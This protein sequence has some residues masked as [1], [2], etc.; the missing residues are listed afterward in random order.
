[1]HHVAALRCERARR[2]VSSVLVAL[3]ALAA[4]P[5]W[6]A[7]GEGPALFGIPVD[8][9]LFGVTLICVG[10]FHHHTLAV[11]LTGLA[12]VMAYKI[13]LT[14]FKTGPGLGGLAAHLAHEWVILTN[15]LGLL[16]GFALLARHFE[17]SRVPEA[18]PRVLPDGWKGGLVLLALIFVLSAFLDNI[19]AALIG[20][21]IAGAVY[22]RKVHIGYL[23]A[24]VAAS[25]AGGA[26]SVVGD[27][28]TTMMWIDGIS[29][30][31]VLPAFIAATAALIVIGIPAAL[32]QQRH[33][34]IVK[35]THGEVHIDWAR[36]W[37]VAI[38]L[39]AAV[40][41]NVTINSTAPELADQV[42]ALG[43]AVWVALLVT[44]TWRR[45]EWSLLPEAFK[46][47]I[48]LL[49]LV[50]IASVMPVERLPAASWQSALTLGFVSS[51][52][53][54]IPL[55]ALALKQ[56]GYDWALLAFAVGFGGSMIWFGSS[57]GVAVSNMYPEARSVGAWLKHGWFVAVAYVV[58]FFVMLALWGWHPSD[59]R[60]RSAQPQPVTHSA[61][62]AA[63]GAALASA[64]LRQ[65]Y[66][67][68]VA[69]TLAKRA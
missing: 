3:C 19:A 32:L 25:N 26:G 44:S 51:V 61:P 69:L 11:A 47:S 5:A 43:L 31:T 52:F 59:N 41:T 30:V 57:A 68:G 34:P 49:A 42:P 56:G 17:D 2:F 66:E 14:G 35:D 4:S 22:R 10:I 50:T 40:A 63:Q 60:G 6:A 58:G 9:I 20:A 48:F 24:I 12:V 53:D 45:P 27:T 54:N 36:V 67:A 33:S 8:F 29:P 46:G 23:A 28:T 13:G 16:L 1:M 37:I 38:I 55:T 62:Y 39:V 21:T 65:A 7:A 18:L 64:G 15:L